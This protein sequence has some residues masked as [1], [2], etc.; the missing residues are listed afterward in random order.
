MRAGAGSAAGSADASAWVNAVA[1]MSGAVATVAR[2]VVAT[3]A[4]V[5]S[6]GEAPHSLEDVYL[7]LVDPGTTG[8]T[9]IDG[10]EHR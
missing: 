8:T 5:L 1:V 3:G 10:Q 4:D 7:L 2:A 6:I 9:G